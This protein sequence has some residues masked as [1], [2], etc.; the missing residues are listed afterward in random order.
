[1]RKYRFFLYFNRINMQ[2]GLAHVWSVHYRG[3][4][5]Q[6]TTVRLIGIPVETDYKPHGRQ[7][8]AKLVG[9]AANLAHN[10]DGGVT[11]W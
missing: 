4:C 3:L 9:Y 11:L 1:M 7:P 10:D 2:R 5:H 8:R 6:A